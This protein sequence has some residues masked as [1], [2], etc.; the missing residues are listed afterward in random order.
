MVTIYNNTNTAII[1]FIIITN[2]N[3]AINTF[4]NSACEIVNFSFV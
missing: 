1:T 2:I 4:R 3:T